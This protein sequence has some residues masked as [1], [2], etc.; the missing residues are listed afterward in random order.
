MID[1]I[2]RLG[3]VSLE[4]P[5]NLVEIP[6]DYRSI[7]HDRWIKVETATVTYKGNPPK[8]FGVF[9]APGGESFTW[10]NG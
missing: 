4:V 6:S 7:E 1:M 10:I 2:E 9:R 8:D 3:N 5:T